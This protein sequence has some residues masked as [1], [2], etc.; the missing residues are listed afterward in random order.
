MSKLN[1][2]FYYND[3]F[4]KIL[5]QTKSL[6]YVTGYECLI[7][8]VE[9][10]NDNKEKVFYSSELYYIHNSVKLHF[11]KFY[12]CDIFKFIDKVYLL[13]DENTT[14]IIDN[15]KNLPFI[16]CE[17]PICDMNRDNYTGFYKCTHSLCRTCFDKWNIKNNTCPFCRS[18]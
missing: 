15:Y 9:K 10:T 4:Y 13:S 8:R 12:K 7:D 18:E 16:K 11:K 2:F 6:H 5:K 3:R 1:T 14:V 17:C